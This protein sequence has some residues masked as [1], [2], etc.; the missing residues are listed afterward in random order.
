VTYEK[1]NK[2]T[3]WEPTVDLASGV[4]QTADFYREKLDRYLNKA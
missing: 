1:F 4:Q 3:G 2:A